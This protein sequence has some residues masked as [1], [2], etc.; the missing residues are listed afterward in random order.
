MI[1]RPSAILLFAAGFGTRMAP[2]TDTL[3]KPLIKV[4]GQPLLEHAL[5]FCAGLN[6]V[7]NVHYHAD[8]IETYLTDRN[9]QISDER[10]LIR[11]TGGGLKHA[12]NLLASNPVFTMNTDA[13]WRGSNPLTHLAETAVAGDAEALL[14]LVPRARAVGHTGTS[15]FNR[16]ADGRLT[17][18][19]D[20][21]YTGVQ[22]IRTD[23]LDMIPEDAFSMW[24]LWQDMLDRGV[25]YGAIY[26]GAWCDVGRPEN[27]ELAEQML[28][29]DCHV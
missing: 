12:R 9:I 13:V 10:D 17:R 18:G 5:Q 28:K 22:I 19:P 8:Q 26:D 29:A 11:E 1:D 2:L 16:G 4:A 27:I 20:Y 14:L 3:P 21:V 23:R 7:V 6:T 15:G 25:M 24:S